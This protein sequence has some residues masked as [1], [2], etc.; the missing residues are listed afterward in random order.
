MSFLPFKTQAEGN[1]F[2]KWINDKYPSFAKR[3]DISVEGDYKNGF[4]IDGYYFLKNEYDKI[5]KK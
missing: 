1:K 2:R 4:I 5:N 3:F